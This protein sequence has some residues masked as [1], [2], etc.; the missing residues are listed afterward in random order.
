MIHKLCI[1]G[2]VYTM[3]LYNMVCHTRESLEF[4]PQSEL[5]SSQWVNE[6]LQDSRVRLVEV[7]SLIQFRLTHRIIDLLRN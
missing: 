1:S 3:I 5:V 7:I 6:H 4:W 2:H